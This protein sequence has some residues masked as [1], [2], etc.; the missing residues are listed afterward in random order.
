[1]ERV[2]IKD[3]EEEELCSLIIFPVQ[4]DPL[5]IAVLL[6]ASGDKPRALVAGNLGLE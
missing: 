5:G 6:L 1:M 4:P 2:W 3:E